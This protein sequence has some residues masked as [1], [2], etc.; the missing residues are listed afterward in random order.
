MPF[1]RECGKQISGQ[2]GS[3][4]AVCESRLARSQAEV[5]ATKQSQKSKNKKRGKWYNLA[6]SYRYPVTFVFIVLI[7]I[8]HF[9]LVDILG[10]FNVSIP[11]NID[12]FL[13][14]LPT[15]ILR[16][17][18]LIIIGLIALDHDG[19]NLLLTIALLIVLLPLILGIAAALWFAI[20]LWTYGN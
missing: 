10:L 8:N 1:C 19:P 17:I 2:T 4:C 7:L 9:W 13:F 14:N 11:Q 5:N 12:L 20:Q 18:I 16:G 6:K 3:L 15:D